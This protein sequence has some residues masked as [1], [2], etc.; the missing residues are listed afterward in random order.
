MFGKRYGEATNQTFRIQRVSDEELDEA[1]EELEKRGY[2]CVKR[3]S[4][5]S[6][7]KHFDYRENK[8]QKLKFTESET[9]KKCWANMKRVVPYVRGESVNHDKKS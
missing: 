5:E 4:V 6:E 8:G 3:G 2:E 1:I 7:R 9:Y